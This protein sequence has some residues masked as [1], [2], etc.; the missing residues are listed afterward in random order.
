MSV[1]SYQTVNPATGA[2]VKTFAPISDRDLEGVLA[3]A[4]N[5]FET[6]WRKRSVAGRA[7]D[8]CIGFGECSGLILPA[9]PEPAW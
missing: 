2:L 6:D 5:T 9:P 4:H 8:Y 7:R 3:T 1:F